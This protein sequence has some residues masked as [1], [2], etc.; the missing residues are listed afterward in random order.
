MIDSDSDYHF[1]YYLRYIAIHN[2]KGRFA[3]YIPTEILKHIFS[4]ILINIKKKINYNFI[5]NTIYQQLTFPNRS[6]SINYYSN[7]NKP[8]VKE[9]KV[10]VADLP[11]SVTSLNVLHDI[12]ENMVQARGYVYK[13]YQHSGSVIVFEKEINEMKD[14]IVYRDGRISWK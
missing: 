6:H 14:K 4:Y 11:Y 5:C 1:W 2:K 3:H 10:N 8:N 7:L 13:Y 12:I 9:I